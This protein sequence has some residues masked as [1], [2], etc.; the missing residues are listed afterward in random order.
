MTAPP[1][2]TTHSTASAEQIAR[3][4][5]QLNSALDDPHAPLPPREPAWAPDL[6][7]DPLS[8]VRRIDHTNLKPTATPAQIETL[9]AEARQYGFAAVCV[10][11]LYMPLVRQLIDRSSVNAAIV[12]GFPLGAMAAEA[13]AYEASWAIAHGA[14]EIDMVIPVGLL[15]ATEYAQTRSDIERVVDACHA[16]DALCKVII[17]TALLTDE[18]KIAACLLAVAAGADYMKTSTGFGPGGA[19]VADVRLMRAVVGPKIGVK[20]AGGIRTLADARAMLAAGATRLGTSA[21]V[22]IAIGANV[23]EEHPGKD[24]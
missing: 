15:K 21:G 12:V 11:S 23:I 17:E 20:A 8:A 10:N 5:M 24:Q 9:C 3:I 19:T 16:G 6:A 4:R 2:Q 22:A 14:D 1:T 13:T 18:E 7:D